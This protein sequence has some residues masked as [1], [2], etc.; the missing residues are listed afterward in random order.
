[1]K[2]FA[3]IKREYLTRVKTKGFLI[4]TFLLPVMMFAMMMMPAFFMSR[5]GKSAQHKIAI[6]DQ[7]ERLQDK[8][9]A[10]FTEIKNDKGEQRFQVQLFTS[11]EGLDAAKNELNNKVSSGELD[12]Y[13]V[14]LPDIFENNKFEMHAKNVGNFEFVERVERTVSGIVRNMRLEE[15]G[16][17]AALVHRLNSWV[18][19]TTFKVGEEG[20][21]QQRAEVSFLYSLLMGVILYM[22]LLLYGQ[23]VVRAIIEDKNSRV[24]EVIISSVKP[25]QFMAGKVLGI[26]ATGLTQFLIWIVTFM[27]IAGYGLSM[28]QMFSPEISRLP[29]PDV[30]PLVLVSFCIYFLLGYFFYAG[31]GAAIGSMVNTDS[32]AQSYQWIMIFPI[33]ISFFL[34][35]AINNAPDGLFATIMSFIPFFTPILMFA[36]ILNEGAPMWQVGLS[37]LTMGLSVWG[38][39]WL[40]A[41]IFRVGILMYGKKPNLPEVVRWIKYS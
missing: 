7:T 10:S 28:A 33:I 13:L 1:M 30:S 6:I 34:M 27:L 14:I 38:M 18:S 16:L 3:I 2:L 26:G 12:A 29:I 20:S 8:L 24:I 15:S 21:T 17:D 23:F 5:A 9:V 19:V 39:I 36:R 4:G 31:I 22:M 40:S 11:D 32:D 37:V 35:F 25:S 41:R